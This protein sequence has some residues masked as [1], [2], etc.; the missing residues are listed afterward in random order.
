MV[1]PFKSPWNCSLVLPREHI[2]AYYNYE[3]WL[4]Q[5]NQLTKRDAIPLPWTD[6]ML[7]VFGESTFA[8]QPGYWQVQVKADDGQ[9]TV[10]STHQTQYQW[11]VMPL[12]LTNGP[13]RM[14]YH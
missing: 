12:G 9:K 3:N 7:H 8:F 2:R 14:P 5:L 4:L 13:V 11:K 10:F 6:D 1:L